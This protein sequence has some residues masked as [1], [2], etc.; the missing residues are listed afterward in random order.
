MDQPASTG[1]RAA[2]GA[3]P[4]VPMLLLSLALVAWFGFQ[5]YQLTRERQQLM[6][7][8]ASQEPQMEAAARLRAALDTT[9]TAT[10]RL[11][12]GGNT[13]ARVLVEELRKRGITINPGTR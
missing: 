8:R 3:N 10:A 6:A 12:D 2:A 4:F 11:A 9:A 13:S 5:S 7:L 1:H